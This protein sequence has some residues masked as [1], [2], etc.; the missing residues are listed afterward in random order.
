MS[1][2]KISAVNESDSK[3]FLSELTVSELG[4]NLKETDLWRFM[5]D[6]ESNNSKLVRNQ[7]KTDLEQMMAIYPG[8]TYEQAI[9]P[10]IGSG[11]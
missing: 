6:A 9:N 1:T 11:I 10:E 4:E 5:D 7:E 2:I 8:L 3:T